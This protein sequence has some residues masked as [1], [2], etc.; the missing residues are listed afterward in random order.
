MYL[1]DFG[2]RLWVNKLLNLQA[3]CKKSVDSVGKFTYRL[4]SQDPWYSVCHQ[5][6]LEPI[7]QDNGEMFGISNTVYSSQRVQ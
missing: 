5:S 4:Y 2:R 3:V 6:F 7:F 1:N